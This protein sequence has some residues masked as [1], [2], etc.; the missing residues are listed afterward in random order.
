MPNGQGVFKYIG[1]D[2]YTG[3]FINGGMEG[4]GEFKYADGRID[5]GMFKNNQFQQS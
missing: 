1:G 5:K 4:Q 2:V 3:K